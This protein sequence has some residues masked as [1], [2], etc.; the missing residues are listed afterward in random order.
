MQQTVSLSS[1]EA[2]Y[3]SLSNSFCEAIWLKNLL[4]EM[5]LRPNAAIP[6]HIDNKGAE[7]LTKNPSHHSRTKH[8]HT[9]YHFVREF[10]DSKLVMV[11]HVASRDMVADPLTKPL[12][13]AILVRARMA[14]GIF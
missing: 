11:C 6:L 5:N 10:L 8:I 1:T 9:R 12:D 2:E 7:A 14:L 3:K 4:S 13:R